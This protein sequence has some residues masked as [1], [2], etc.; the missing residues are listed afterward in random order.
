MP[1]QLA[2]NATLGVEN[3]WIT[4]PQLQPHRLANIFLFQLTHRR[5]F[6]LG[7]VVA[8]LFTFGSPSEIPDAF[9]VPALPISVIRYGLPWSLPTARG[10]YRNRP[11]P[12]PR[13][14]TRG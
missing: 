12:V 10:V 8:L 9:R 11:S 2:E 1:V 6:H 7:T 5:R 3:L 13:H 14:G 4:T